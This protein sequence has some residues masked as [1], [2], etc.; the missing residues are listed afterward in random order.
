M[1][2]HWSRTSAT[3]FADA[4][5]A[6][7]SSCLSALSAPTAA[8]NVPG[9]RKDGSRKGAREGVQVTQ[10]SLSVAAASRFTAGATSMR[11]SADISAEYARARAGST[12]QAKAGEQVPLA[13]LVHEG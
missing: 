11:S 6:G 4:R 13:E 8:T 7:S 3:T 5:I 9:R 10:T 12:S 1:A 2:T